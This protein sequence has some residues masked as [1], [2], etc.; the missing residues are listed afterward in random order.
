[1]EREHV[2]EAIVTRMKAR[3]F[4]PF[5]IYFNDGGF[6]LVEHPETVLMKNGRA[7]YM[8][9]TGAM[10]IFDAG[11]ISRFQDVPEEPALQG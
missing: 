2:E 9:R 8:N 4:M 3:P 5:L 1:V 7:V 6:V 10:T 11:S